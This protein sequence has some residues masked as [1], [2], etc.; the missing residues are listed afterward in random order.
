MS[1]QIIRIELLENTAQVDWKNKVGIHHS[2]IPYYSL[3][4]HHCSISLIGWFENPA[5]IGGKMQHTFIY[6]P[7]L[8]F[9]QV[10]NDLPALEKLLINYLEKWQ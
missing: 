2:V 4:R 5:S 6:N 1:T 9:E 7:V 10:I 3:F 8:S